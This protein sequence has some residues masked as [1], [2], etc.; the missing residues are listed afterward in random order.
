MRILKKS[1]IFSNLSY[2]AVHSGSQSFE[3]QDKFLTKM[4]YFIYDFGRINIE[5]KEKV[6]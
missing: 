4:K 2:Y 5:L 6:K 3:A 1:I